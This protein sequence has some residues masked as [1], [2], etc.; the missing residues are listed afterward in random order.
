M[1]LHLY[2]TEVSTEWIDYNQHMNAGYYNVVFDR[3]VE[4]LLDDLDARD[5]M[6]RTTGTF[7]SVET[8]IRY[9]QELKVGSPLRVETQIVGLD[10]KRLHVYTT[11]YHAEAGY[12]AASGETMLL[13]VKQDQ[14]KVVP[15]D[16]DFLAKLES[17]AAA[18]RGF[19][20]PEAAGQGIRG[21]KPKQ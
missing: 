11:I 20:R 21:V 15:I 19:P 2:Q 13:H 1:P 3:A 16:P 4:A 12:A 10:A 6:A 8:H 17:M 7:Y 9:L 18:H 5:Y 14:G